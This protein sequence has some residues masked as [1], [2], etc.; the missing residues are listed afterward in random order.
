MLSPVD[1]E[2]FQVFQLPHKSRL[3]VSFLCFSKFSRFN[4]THLQV[5]SPFQPSTLHSADFLYI[6]HVFR[7]SLSIW[8]HFFSHSIVLS[9]FVLP[10]ALWSST[11]LLSD[12]RGDLHDSLTE[13]LLICTEIMLVYIYFHPETKNMWGPPSFGSLP[14]MPTRAFLLNIEF[15]AASLASLVHIY[16]RKL[17]Y[18]VFW[19]S[20]AFF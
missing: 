11:G 18:C 16:A 2:T 7:I 19:L 9:D 6:L 13:Y 5:S 15:T 3:N 4:G 17:E 14:F 20:D 12:F 8:F 1:R 10:C